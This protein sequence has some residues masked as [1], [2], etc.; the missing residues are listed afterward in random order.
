MPERKTPNRK[1]SSVQGHT[2][3]QSWE[4]MGRK[5]ERETPKN[6][7]LTPTR[8]ENNQTRPDLEGEGEGELGEVDSCRIKDL[9]RRRWR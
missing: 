3:K 5:E 7:H 4:G 1:T 2:A 9:T 8:P 6:I